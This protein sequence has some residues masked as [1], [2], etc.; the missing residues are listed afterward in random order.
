MHSVSTSGHSST[1]AVS[2]G[3]GKAERSEN[4]GILGQCCIFLLFLS[5]VDRTLCLLSISEQL[6]GHW[7]SA[8]GHE[9]FSWSWNDPQ[10]RVSRIVV[11]LNLTTDGKTWK[12]VWL[13]AGTWGTALCSSGRA[14]RERDR[15][16][17]G[18]RVSSCVT[19]S[20]CS[21]GWRSVESRTDKA[22]GVSVREIQRRIESYINLLLLSKVKDLGIFKLLSLGVGFSVYN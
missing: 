13:G 7:T 19:G 18:A 1:C 9:V 17:A 14:R 6:L 4:R 12:G 15:G 10:N 22:L 20:Q 11:A 2:Y 5:K 16:S 3:E 8:S 21:L